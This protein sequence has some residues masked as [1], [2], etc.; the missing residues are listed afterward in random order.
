MDENLDENQDEV[1]QLEA[2]KA[3]LLEEAMEELRKEHHSQDQVL[4]MAKRLAQLKGQDPDKGTSHTKILVY[5]LLNFLFFPH[6]LIRISENSSIRGRSHCC[7][8]Y[9][10]L[11]TMEDFQHPDSD[12]ET[13][14]EAVMRVLKQVWDLMQKSSYFNL[15]YNKSYLVNPLLLTAYHTLKD[16]SEATWTRSAGHKGLLFSH[17]NNL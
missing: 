14:E 9:A 13:E 4:D 16:D 3:R 5:I 11:V 6:F 15:D 2:E 17:F 12:E 8:C 10:F 7:F 1:K